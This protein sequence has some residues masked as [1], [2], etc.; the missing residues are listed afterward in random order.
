MVNALNKAQLSRTVRF[1]KRCRFVVKA[2]GYKPEGRVFE[3][4]WGEILNLPYPSG[5]TR[6]VRGADNL[7]AIYEPIV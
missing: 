6:L 4:W 7:T 5:R 3:T 2:L 1:W